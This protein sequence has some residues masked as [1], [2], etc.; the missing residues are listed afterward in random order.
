[1]KYQHVA[2]EILIA[3]G[4]KENIIDAKHCMTRLRLDLKDESVA[5]KKALEKM[6]EVIAVVQSGGQF[7]IVIGNHVPEVFQQL[8]TLIEERDNR[9]GEKVAKQGVFNRFIDTISSIFTPVLGVLA[10][11]GMIKSITAA[12]VSF[13]WLTIDSG[14]YKLLHATGDSL[15]YFFPIFL[16]YTAS[17]KFKLPPFLGMI[18]GASL[19]HPGM[20]GIASSN[21][22]PLYV[23]FQGTIIESPVYM[24]FLGIP[25]ITMDYGASIIP[26]VIAIYFAAKIYK[27]VDRVTPSV[28]KSF[29]VPLITLLV[30]VPLTFLI[31]GPIATW[32]G[33]LLGWF[34]LSL[35]HLNPVIAGAIIGGTW[36]LLVMLGLHWGVIP[37]SINNILT[38]GF[39]PILALGSATSFA[40]AGVVLGVVIKT[41]N[42]TV[43]SLG[44]SAFISSLLGVSEPSIYG[45]TLP[46]KKP[47]YATLFA[48]SVAGMIVGLFG[49]RLFNVGGLGVFGIAN[50]INPELGVDKE[51][52]GYLIAIS[53]A[54]II[55]LILSLTVGYSNE[56]DPIDEDKTKEKE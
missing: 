52:Y 22:E 29:L 10:A 45:I 28:V 41:K 55:G 3:I 11:T 40:T 15:M 39:D 32:L 6:E 54:F 38:M 43:K 36:Q 9:D 35:Y 44:I 24:T 47:F 19:V 30:V 42:K 51:F 50:Y 53:V 13:N 23:L 12:F 48:S 4:G 27:K 2:K 34:T 33:D 20:T 56:M 5:D 26:I 46:R 21:M 18:I 1:M 49:S 16:G 37:I 7:Q 17:K 8:I 25:I 14:T 31:I